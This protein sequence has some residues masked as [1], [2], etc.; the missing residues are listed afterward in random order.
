MHR[1][2]L[3]YSKENTVTTRNAAVF[4]LF[5]RGEPPSSARNGLERVKRVLLVLTP[6][7]GLQPPRRDGVC[8][9]PSPGCF[10]SPRLRAEHGISELEGTSKDRHRLLAEELGLSLS[11]GESY[12]DVA[13]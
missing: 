12:G 7:A 2:I 3:A 4:T 10:S 6:L 11:C 5:L 9:L 8:V 13:G 1:D